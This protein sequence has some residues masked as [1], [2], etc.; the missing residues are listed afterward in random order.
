LAGGVTSFHVGYCAVGGAA[1]GLGWPLACLFALA[2][3]ATMG[4]LAS[5]FPTAGGLYHWAAVLGGR[6]AGW[7]TAWFNLLGLVTVLAAINLLVTFHNFGGRPAGEKAVWP[8]TDS[9]V[10]LFALGLLLPMYT[11]TGYDASAHVAEETKQAGVTVP[12]S[13]LRAVLVSG[14]FGFVM[15][16]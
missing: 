12:R 7:L 16:A 14:L 2:V 8:P 9:L 5:A 11:L 4:Q 10:V 15:L 13:M 1:V 6:G 3:A